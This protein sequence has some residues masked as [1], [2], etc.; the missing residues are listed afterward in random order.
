MS[1]TKNYVFGKLGN[2]F[3][4][5]IYLLIAPFPER[6][7]LSATGSNNTASLTYE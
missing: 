7:I 3:L 4:K 5:F 1:A 2:F 6:Y